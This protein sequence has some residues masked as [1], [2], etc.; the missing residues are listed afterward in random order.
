MIEKTVKILLLEDR[1]SEAEF[2]K[3]SVL[4]HFPNAVFTVADGKANF[5]ER[6]TWAPYDVVLGDYHLPDYNGLEAL[7][8]VRRNYPE[9]PFIFVTGTLNSE[10][11]A[12]DAI[13]QGAN[14]YVL[15]ENLEYLGEVL[16]KVLKKASGKAAIAME[17]QKQKNDFK[18]KIQ[19]AAAILAGAP[20][21][22]E[23]DFVDGVLAE[24]ANG[25]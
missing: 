5:L 17:Q 23:K 11:K 10:E 20:D 18:I 25:L 21:F 4:K 14:G 12:A 24:A 2:T 6:I 9:M 3:R 16:E 1:K 7:L 13:L 15:K 22:S 8:H 19:R